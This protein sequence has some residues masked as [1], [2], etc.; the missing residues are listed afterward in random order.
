LEPCENSSFV[1]AK[2]F[3]H[4]IE[5][6]G[7]LKQQ[8]AA[9]RQERDSLAE[10]RRVALKVVCVPIFMQGKFQCRAILNV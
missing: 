3:D 7:A 5:T 8:L 4:L 9:L 6:S 10:E 2:A 1:I